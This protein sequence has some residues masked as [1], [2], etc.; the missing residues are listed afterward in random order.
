MGDDL[1]NLSNAPSHDEHEEVDLLEQ[2]TGNDLGVKLD[3]PF[4][5]HE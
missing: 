4:E 3:D 1:T 5:R 2:P